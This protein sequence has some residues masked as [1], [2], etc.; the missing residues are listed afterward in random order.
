MEI[1]LFSLKLFLITNLIISPIIS[2]SDDFFDLNH[3]QKPCIIY[4]PQFMRF[5]NLT[6]TNLNKT[7]T[8]EKENLNI[9]KIEIDKI[10][11][12]MCFPLND[13]DYDEKC[14]LRDKRAVGYILNSTDCKTIIGAP[15]I[16]P[17][18]NH[19]WILIMLR[20]VEGDSNK[21]RA[22]SL[23]DVK[24]EKLFFSVKS[25]LSGEDLRVANATNDDIYGKGSD[26]IQ[27]NLDVLNC[28]LNFVYSFWNG[29]DNNFNKFI[30]FSF[31]VFLCF[32]A[33]TIIFNQND[34]RLTRFIMGGFAM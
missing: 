19:K 5:I 3:I 32:L 11:I 17:L 12:N 4:D 1:N 10:V 31:F 30:K 28:D 21:L 2:I 25:K 8:I 22:S 9:T 15:Y 16:S 13:T 24:Y 33:I 26:F 18:S 34:S 27:V 29:K 20:T 23:D 7:I 14:K 6:K